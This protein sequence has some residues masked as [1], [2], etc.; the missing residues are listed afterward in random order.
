MLPLPLRSWLCSGRA[1]RSARRA[2]GVAAAVVAASLTP[3]IMPG[4]PVLVA[5]VVAIVVGWF[6]WLGRVDGSTA[7]PGEVDR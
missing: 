6:N 1:S 4:L 7:G 2:V 3:L 5:A